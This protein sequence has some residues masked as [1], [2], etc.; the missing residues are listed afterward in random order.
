MNATSLR[1]WP[2]RL[3]HALLYELI[4]LVLL[5]PLCSW[6]TGHDSSHLGGLTL[7][8]SLIAMSW[9][10]LF[11][12]VFDQLELRAGHHLSQRRW[13]SRL[14]H[15]LLFEGGLTLIT[16]PLIAVWLDLGLW[17]ALLL[18]AGMLGFYL[19]YTVLF[20]WGYD[21]SFRLQRVA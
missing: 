4:G 20:N 6:I 13:P 2:D 3:R 17:Q 19:V 1:S 18:D 12:R 14:L 21:L 9:N 15:A 5:V 16:L 8:I 10:A 7:C 11:N